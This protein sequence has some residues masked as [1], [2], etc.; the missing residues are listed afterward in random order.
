RDQRVLSATMFAAQVDFTY[1]GDLLVFIDE[2]QLRTLERQMEE[3]GYL[4]GQKMAM[5]FNM[6][7]S[8][9]LV[10]PYVV[11]NY[12]KGKAPFPF[13]LLYWNS[14][15]TRIPAPTPPFYLPLFYW[16]KRLRRGKRVLGAKAPAP[17]KTPIPI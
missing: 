9:D 3:T 16:E 15:A 5:A 6:L 11:N 14:D 12:L 4:E 1:G 2:E 17:G 7:R 8:N 10:W 13:D